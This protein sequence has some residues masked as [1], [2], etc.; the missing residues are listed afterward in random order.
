MAKA[1]DTETAYALVVAFT[2]QDQRDTLPAI[3]HSDRPHHQLEEMTVYFISNNA[4]INVPR[5]SH[6]PE[7]TDVRALMADI[8]N[9]GVLTYADSGAS[10]HCFVNKNDFSSYI[11]FP[12]A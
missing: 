3:H 12:E 8:D 11:E 7:E 6:V 4:E 2:P 10:N 9:H 5:V 1:A